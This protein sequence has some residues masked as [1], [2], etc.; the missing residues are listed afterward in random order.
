MVRKILWW[1]LVL[2][3]IS[4]VA[5]WIWTGGIA[6]A[7]NQSSLF[8]NLVDFIFY[9][10]PSTGA[11]LRLPWQP[12]FPTGAGIPETQT[13]GTASGV[14]QAQGELSSLNQQYNTL[15]S[16][17][18]DAKTFGNPSPLAGRV[19]ILSE[20]NPRES[21]VGAEYIEIASVSQNTAPIDLAGWSL[22][23][24]YTG[25]RAYIP[26]AVSSFLAGAVNNVA[27]IQLAPGQGLILNSG[28]SPVGVSFRENSCSGY[29]GQMQ[30]FT[31]AL[32]TDCPSPASLLPLTPDNLRNYGQTCSDYLS[33]VPSCEA[34]L[35]TFPP[36]VSQNCRAFAQDNLSY[37]GCVLKNRYS[38]SF[39]RDV[40]RVFLNGNL[41]LWQNGHDIIRLLDG[42]GRTVDVLTY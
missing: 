25:M 29:L 11:T 27:P 26:P 41:E 13:D 42:S 24:A 5:T 32:S 16:Q 15:N 4:F 23:S 14:V 40:W 30:L 21:A 33:S 38:P 7:R 18:E 35:N 28:V 19:R 8:T 3:I 39:T 9:H 1:I 36:E 6:K 2:L 10:D 17:I 31:P 22:Q 37:N 34:P 12:E 20:G